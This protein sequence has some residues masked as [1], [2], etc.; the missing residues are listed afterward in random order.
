[1]NKNA[2]VTGPNFVKAANHEPLTVSA[3]Q[4]ILDAAWKTK[5]AAYI[6]LRL[7]AGLRPVETQGLDLT[8]NLNL[9]AGGVRVNGGRPYCRQVELSPAVVKMLMALQAEGRLPRVM[10]KPP[11]G[12]MEKLLKEAGADSD[13]LRRTA[14]AYYLAEYADAARTSYWG[15]VSTPLL[16]HQFSRVTTEQARAFWNLLPNALVSA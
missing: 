7:W 9:E 1:M 15:G 10:V 11:R 6:I 12:A 16:R 4:Q 5:F 8:Q 3:A 13:Q 2:I 14:L